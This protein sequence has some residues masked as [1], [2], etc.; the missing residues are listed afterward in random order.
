MKYKGR[1]FIDIFYIDN[2]KSLKKFEKYKKSIFR[3]FF[4]FLIISLCKY[5]P[6]SSLKKSL[7]RLIGIK[8]G[9]NVGICSEIRFDYTYSE[10]IEIGDNSI[11]GSCAKIFAHESTRKKI[12]I[13]KTI[14]GKNVLVGGSSFIAA[15]V[16]IGDNSTISH[17][18]FVN[19]SIKPRTI[20]EGNPIK[21]LKR[22]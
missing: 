16:R 19:K 13:G 12:K 4:N 21:E 18:S 22:R 3:V 14:I 20:V 15:G 1:N 5:L 6:Y 2:K 8:I 7:Y 9:K 10:L 11:I 17:C